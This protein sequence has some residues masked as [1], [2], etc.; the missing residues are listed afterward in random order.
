MK[1]VLKLFLVALIT[2]AFSGV[3]F[4]QAKP[5]TPA[6]PATPASPEK[7]AEKAGKKEGQPKAT[8]VTGEIMSLDAKAGTLRVKVKDKEMSFTAETK[9]AKSALEK[10]KVGDRVSVSYTEKNG[11]LIARSVTEGKA[12]AKGKGKKAEAK[13]EGKKGQ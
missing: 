5:A 6:T 2:L 4:A 9:G 8:R 7:K 12:K 3:G 10:V 11:K 13:T 1:G